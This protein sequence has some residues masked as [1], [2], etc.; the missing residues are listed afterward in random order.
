MNYDKQDDIQYGQSKLYQIW[1]QYKKETNGDRTKEIVFKPD[2]DTEYTVE[3]P[4][5]NYVDWLEMKLCETHTAEI[6]AKTLISY[7]KDAISKVY[8]VPRDMIE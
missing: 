2:P 7:L 1:K 5:Q 6:D 4:S 8:N 3:I